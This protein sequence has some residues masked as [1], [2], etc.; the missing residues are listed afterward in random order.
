MKSISDHLQIIRRTVVIRDLKILAW[1]IYAFIL[2]IILL[3]VLFESV[4]YFSPFIRYSLWLLAASSSVLFLVWLILRSFAL[5]SNKIERYRW[6]VLAKKAG[7]ELFTKTD[8]IINALQ[9]ER[10]YGKNTSSSL[11]RSFI[12]DSA[13]KLEKLDLTTV[14]SKRLSQYWKYVTFGLLIV[15]LIIP[16]LTWRHSV[17]AIYRWAHPQTEFIPPLPLTIKSL[18]GHKQLLGGEDITINF[19]VNGLIPDSITVELRSISISKIEDSL[20]YIKIPQ[21]SKTGLN[22]SKIGLYQLRLREV[23]HDISYR[24]YVSSSHF[25]QPW[26]EIST[27]PFSISVIDRPTLEMFKIS[28]VSPEYSRLPLQ[29]Q[30]ANQ[31]E[32]LALKGSSIAIALTSNRNLSSG[33]LILNDQPLAMHISGR[34]AGADFPLMEEGKFFISLKDERGISNRKPIPYHLEIIPDRLPEMSIIEPAPIVELTGNQII[35]IKLTI[36]DDFGFSNLQVAYEIRRPSYIQAEPFISILALNIQK[37]TPKQE[38]EVDWS[39]LE[40]G[41]MP[42]DEVHYHFELY[43]N[44]TVSGPKKS[45]SS[46]F[47]AR[48]PSL[49]DLF[50]KFIEK[51]EKITEKIEME[52]EDVSRLK[53]ELKKVELE[54][55]KTDKPDW[56]QKQALRKTLEDVK[57]ELKDFEELSEKIEAL[58]NDGDKNNLFSDDM[59]NKFEELQKLIEEIFPPELREK[60]NSLEDALENITNQDLLDA[61]KNLTENMEQVEMELDRFLDIFRRVQAEQKLDEL[62]KRIEQL[63]QV[64]ENIHRDIPAQTKTD[65]SHVFNKLNREEEQNLHNYADLMNSIESAVDPLKEFSSQSAQ[66]LQD[67]SESDLAQS[68]E[69]NLENTAQELKRQDGQKSNQSSRN[70]LDDLDKMEQRINSIQEQFQTE[71]VQEISQ[72]FRQILRDILE[73]S[74]AQ[75]ALRE[76]TITT[77]RISPRLGALAGEQQ[78]LQ[79]QLSHIMGN[80]MNLSKQTFSVT[81]EM[82]R[83]MG[84]TY[85]EMEES[86]TKLGERNG[87]GSLNNQEQA[88]LRLNQGARSILEAIKNM[89]STGSASGYAEFL[90]KMGEMSGKQQGINAQGM[91][92]GLGQMSASMQQA[93]LQEMLGKQQGVRKSLGQLMDEMNA[94]GRQG[95]G[96]LKGIAQDMDDVIKDIQRREFSVE[97]RKRQQ[98]ILSRM[99]DSQKSLTKRGFEDKRKSETAHQDVYAGPGGLPQDLGQRQSLFIEALNRSL[100]SGYSLDYQEM[101]RR[102]FNRLSRNEAAIL[103]DSSDKPDSTDKTEPALK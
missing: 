21:T 27:D 3:A 85:S 61:L 98:R 40:L 83:S 48:L 99:L 50:K 1:K 47:I 68:L 5:N 24:A 31:A 20:K 87:Q 69:N 74:K 15:T 14:F 95:L 8:T 22:K 57:Q 71:T 81:P 72:K 13:Q 11:A 43:D 76:E 62:K 4:F 59:L 93:M 42:E 10:D 19:N 90:K 55:L 53:E 52:L 92:L 23:F 78:L 46:T 96:D 102:Y 82:G 77:P 75:E 70:T 63:K 6:S 39:L 35:P 41:L 38:I 88:M 60:L 17:S 29:I 66:A 84:Q 64:Q 56:D 80:M 30:K 73:L 51:E 94:S 44:D 100:K 49:N 58:K 16:S 32:V 91:Q 86:K 34:K 7:A 26:N 36:E 28:I 45:I 101:I 89:Q 97:T 9:L 12:R 67:L 37:E 33:E 25:W 54:L 65:N 103:P 79:D 2:I 18:D